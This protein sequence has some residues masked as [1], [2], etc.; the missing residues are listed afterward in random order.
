MTACISAGAESGSIRRNNVF[1]RL[2]MMKHFFGC[3]GFA[4][5]LVI[6]GCANISSPTG[7]KKDITPPALL[8]VEPAD[9]LTNI[10]VSKLSMYFDEYLTVG[11]ATKEVRI[12]P[13]LEIPPTL[14]G[15]NKHVV[16][17][18]VDSLLEDNTTYRISFGG[19]IRDLHENNPFTGYTYTFSTGGYFDSLQLGGSVVNAA[20]GL[21]DSN[22]ITILLY[23]AS[24]NDSAIV[25]KKPKYATTP[26]SR[27]RFLFRGL[28]GR[29]FRLYAVRDENNNMMYD[30]GTEMIAFS[31]SMAVPA[32]SVIRSIELRIFMELPD[33]AAVADTAKPKKKNLKQKRKSETVVDSNLTWSTNIDTSSIVRRTFDV[34]DS[35]RLVFNR[36]PLIDKS[37]IHFSL[38]SSG[39]D[40]R[41]P[42]EIHSDNASENIIYILAD[43]AYNKV[44]SL[45]LDSAF[46]VDTGG[47]AAGAATYKFRTLYE[48]DY[49]KIQMNIPAKYVSLS[50]ASAAEP[51]YLLMVKAEDDTLCVQKI[52]DTT[53][54]FERLKPAKYTFR[55]IVDKNKDG[56]WTTGNLFERIQPEFVIPC[57]EPVMVKAAWEHI[58][59]FEKLPPKDAPEEGALNKEK[60]EKSNR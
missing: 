15:I 10:R 18:L 16:L 9:S 52:T 28:P 14:T 45:E 6:A 3:I 40:E 35:I 19:A 44:Y 47:V 60:L 11:D 30:G 34:T 29:N 54:F 32:D 49:G 51:D 53:M 17:K 22:G 46:A 41:V 13:F 48:K 26:D 27:G 24:E 42:V 12:Q 57:D 33:S 2:Q 43:M 5:M 23:A 56:S 1:L 36:A 59:D 38:K 4:C 50:G 39:G 58:A 8:R 25:K 37:K 20:T 7:G 21:P 31:D 55:I